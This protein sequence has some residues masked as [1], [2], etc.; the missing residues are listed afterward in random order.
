MKPGQLALKIGGYPLYLARLR[1]QLGWRALPMRQIEDRLV[2]TLLSE[3]GG[4]IDADIVTIITTY[5]RPGLLPHAI[6]SA[7]TQDVPDHHVIVID[8]AGG[9]LPDISRDPRLTVLSLPFNTGTAGVVRNVGMRIS[10]S[11]LIAFLDDDNTWKP[12]HLPLS[13]AAHDGRVTLT[14]TGIRRMHADGSVFDEVNVPW[15]RRAMKRTAFVDTSA[16]VVRRDRGVTF[17]RIP[18]RRGA[19]SPGEDWEF[20]YRL[21]RRRTVVHVPHVTVNYLL[22]NMSHYATWRDPMVSEIDSTR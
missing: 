11:R 17:S 8:D 1:V 19:N 18:R 9:E 21:S 22:D 20:V 12:E 6:A 2:A 13:V 4:P 10:R 5:K 7:L 3:L 16:I 14:Y 15:S